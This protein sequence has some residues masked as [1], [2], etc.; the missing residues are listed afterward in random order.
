MVILLITNGFNEVEALKTVELLRQSNVE[1]KTVSLGDKVVTGAHGIPIVCDLTADEVNLDEVYMAILPVGD[2]QKTNLGSAPIAEK[3]FNYL[4]SANGRI[5]AVCTADFALENI[6]QLKANCRKDTEEEKQNAHGKMSLEEFIASY[7]NKD[8]DADDSFFE[9]V[10]D[11]KSCQSPSEGIRKVY[12]PRFVEVK[13]KEKPDYSSY[14]LPS[15]DLL[16]RNADFTD[17]DAQT[18]IQEKA[19]RIIETLASF[20]VTASIM[21]VD[22]GPRITR[23]EVVPARG[24][25][26][27][28]IL[29]LTDDL[30]LSLAVG[31]IRMEAPIPGKSAIGIEVPN[32]KASPV[33]LRELL[34]TE[35][36]QNSKSKTAVCIGRDV[37]GQPVFGDIA[38][39]PHLLV[40]GAVGMGKS[41]CI[42]SLIISVLCK[43]KPDEVKFILIDPKQ[44]EFTAYNDI[45]HLLIPMLT[46]PPARLRGQ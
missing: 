32:K 30:A 15:P 17:E 46:K 43:A 24:V 9:V 10:D 42:N 31:S 37:A 6:D 34:E 23:Y 44:V 39:M 36:F 41:V 5:A 28:S 45:P 40:A 18:E 12:T 19:D 8:S 3:L 27:S 22:R 11:E 7:T 26:V 21:G 25:K 4:T 35:D 20:G 16:E 1:T 29:N 38:K 13:K 14:K 33:R 2:P